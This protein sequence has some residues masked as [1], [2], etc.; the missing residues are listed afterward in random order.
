MPMNFLRRIEGASFPVLI[1][2]EADIQ[3]AAVLAAAQLVEANLPEPG[4]PAS[5]GAVILRITPM[6]RAELRRLRERGE[7]FAAAPASRT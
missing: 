2:D 7:D 5:K 6:G 4:E 3:C 1:H